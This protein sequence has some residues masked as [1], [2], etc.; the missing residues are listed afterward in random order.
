MI[1]CVVEMFGLSPEVSELRSVQIELNEGASLADLIAGLKSRIPALEGPVIRPGE[2]RLTEQYA[3]NIN[4]CFCF[5]GSEL[6]IKD[7]DSVA[8]LTLAVGG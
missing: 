3:F 1:K 8:L 7:G 2:N 6:Q 5:D 4:G